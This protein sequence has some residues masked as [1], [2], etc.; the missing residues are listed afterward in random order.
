MDAKLF[1]KHHDAVAGF[2]HAAAGSAAHFRRVGLDL[3]EGPTGGA[4]RI[5]QAALKDG[6]LRF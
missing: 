2:H 5:T 3:C 4:G 1:P 6:C